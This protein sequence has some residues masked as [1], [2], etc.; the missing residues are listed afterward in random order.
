MNEILLLAG[1]PRSGT[2]FI[3]STL[4]SHPKIALFSE[5][6]MTDILRSLDEMLILAESQRPDASTTSISHP[7]LR[8]TWE[9]YDEIFRSVFRSVYPKKCAS[10]FGAKMPAIAASED[11]DYLLE[12]RS[13][14]KFIYVLRNCTST[15]ASSM[16]RYE[17]TIQGK[18]NWPYESEAQALNEW[19]YSLLIGR[20]IA[21]HTHVLFLKYEDIII[22]QK[23]ETRRISEFLGIEPFNFDVNMSGNDTKALPRTIATY[24]AELRALV[25]NWADLSVDEI[26]RHSLTTVRNHLCSD[27]QN[28]GAARCD[29]GTHINFNKPEPWGAWSRAGFFALKPRFM[30]T[31]AKLAGMELEFLGK[32]H[33]IDYANLSAFSNSNPL[34]V[35]IIDESESTTSVRISIPP[36]TSVEKDRPVI[37]MFF[38]LW[39]RSKGDPRALGLRLKRYRLIWGDTGS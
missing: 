2:T 30:R 36:S 23:K 15:V 16:R 26:A 20:Y 17:A 6:N 19:V 28:M 3:G 12:H 22:N 8:P 7:F 27:W 38:R 18:D 33:Q 39:V 34:S 35:S 24:P 14:P 32:R 10:I 25:Q 21:E 5:F 9:D 11:I 31:D 37:A 1:S 13:K 4:N 29:I